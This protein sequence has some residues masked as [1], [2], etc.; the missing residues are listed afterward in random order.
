VRRRALLLAALAGLIATTPGPTGAL[1]QATPEYLRPLDLRASGAGWQAVNDFRLDWELGAPLAGTVGPTAVHYRILDPSGAAVAPPVRLPWYGNELRHL[2]IPSGPGAY[3]A[4]VWLEDETGQGPSARTPLLFD[5]SRPDIPQVTG[6]SGWLGHGVPATVTI[7][8]PTAPAP[9]SGIAGYA[10]SVDLAAQGSPCSDLSS[11]G[12]GELDP[13]AGGAIA[14]G[15]LPEGVNFLHLVAVSGSGVGSAVQHVVVRADASPPQVALEGIPTGWASGPVRISATATDPHSG[16]GAAGPAG[17]IT[18]LA[19]D[20]GPPTLSPGPTV[21]TTVS[22][23]GVHRV[24]PYAR[25]AAGNVHGGTA[26]TASP[27]SA[28][29]R[30]DTTAPRVWFAAAQDHA[31]PERIEAF[32]SDSLAGPSA[33]R[34]AI[35]VRPAGSRGQFAPIPTAVS[36]GRLVARWDSEAHPPGT[37]EFRATGYDV[38]GNHLSGGRRAGGAKMVLVNPLKTTTHLRVGFG[39]RSHSRG[40]SHGRVLPYGRRAVVSGRL[41]SSESAPLPGRRVELVESLGSGAVPAHRATTVLTAE[42][43]SFLARLRPGPSRRVVVRFP[44]DAVLNSAGNQQLALRVPSKVRIRAS[45]GRAAV[46][47]RPVV[48]SG[49]VGHRGA[50]IPAAGIAVELQF[51]V[52][53]SDWSE[54]RTV[55][56]DRRGRFRYPYAFSDDDSRGV[57]FQFRAFVPAQAGW[58]YEPAPSRRVAVTGR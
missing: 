5:D 22:G 16:M 43:G 6:P 18:A 7:E 47:G 49:Q 21:A 28:V 11:C 1:A 32:V 19:I 29:V 15:V 12:G 26:G 17:P 24:E 50:A 14:L 10:V 34:G 56:T 40:W 45:A 58:P 37:Y 38:A 3:T 4:E 54:F 35:A 33:S 42:D 36:A 48:F 46:G 31:D 8:P 30:I 57:R 55:Q 20:G 9:P 23:D 25:D 41:T 44:G 2:R 53:G 27:S 51:R 52:A 13:A 39:G